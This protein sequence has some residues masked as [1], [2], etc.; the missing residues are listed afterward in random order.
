MTPEERKHWLSI[1]LILCIL[2]IVYNLAEGLFSVYFGTADDTLALLGFGIDSFVEVISGLGIL[3]MVLRMKTQEVSRHDLFE[4]QALR[5]TGFAFYLLAAGLIAGIILNLVYKIK[6]STTLPGIIIALIS[7]ASM[8]FLMHYKIRAGKALNSAA[9]LSDARC[10][11]TCIYLSTILLASSALYAW[12]RI[13]YIDLAGSL[14]IAW[15][16]WSE[17]KEAFEKV[18]LNKIT[19]SCEDCH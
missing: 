5:V 7:L 11:R 9:I 6:P 15:F 4:R 13:P 18:R 12:L 1:S 14:G 17:G 3:H 16:A 8:Y 10:T 19:C 2:T